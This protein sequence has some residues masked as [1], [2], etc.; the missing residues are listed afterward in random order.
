MKR[1]SAA[2]V[3]LSV[4]VYIPTGTTSFSM[5]TQHMNP[6]STHNFWIGPLSSK[7]YQFHCEAGDTLDGAFT[8]TLDGDQYRGDQQKYDHWVGWGGGVDFYILDQ[9]EYSSWSEEEN[10]TAAFVMSDVTTL[11]WSFDISRSGEWYVVYDND[12]SVYGKQVEGSINHN[13]IGLVNS[14]LLLTIVGST[15]VLVTMAVYAR[16]F[17][18]HPK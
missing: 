12:S 15:L 16:R 13:D 3:V 11:S 1:L 14:F 6:L 8:V 18:A 17:F 10:F 9:I 2:L 7:I 5:D 4:L